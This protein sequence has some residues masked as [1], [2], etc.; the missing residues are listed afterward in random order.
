MHAANTLLGFVLF[1]N[2]HAFLIFLSVAANIRLELLLL[3]I[4]K[5]RLKP[6]SNVLSSMFIYYEGPTFGGFQITQPPA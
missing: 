3:Y 2:T 1:N 5:G 6:V 4:Q